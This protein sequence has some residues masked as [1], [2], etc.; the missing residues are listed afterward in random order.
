MCNWVSPVLLIDDTKV[1]CFLLLLD[2]STPY[3]LVK[4]DAVAEA[5]LFLPN[6]A[7]CSAVRLNQVSP[8]YDSQPE[9]PITCSPMV[10]SSVIGRWRHTC[11]KGKYW[12]HSL[13]VHTAYKGSFRILSSI[14]SSPKKVP[15]RIRRLFLRS[16]WA[17]NLMGVH[18]LQNNV[19]GKNKDN[20]GTHIASVRFNVN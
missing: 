1:F 15:F 4:T 5:G 12:R 7:L 18:T 8:R 2:L 13:F 19:I 10:W 3:Y 6:P 14:F 20:L 11:P 16:S 9:V 17:W